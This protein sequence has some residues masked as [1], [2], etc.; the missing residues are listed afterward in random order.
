MQPHLL[1]SISSHGYGHAGQTAP[2][3]N[4][5]RREVPNLRV[6]LRTTLPA[7]FLARRFDGPF[8]LVAEA[9]DFGMKMV[10]AIEVDR[11]SSAK[12]YRAF[13]ANWEERVAQEAQRLRELRPDLILANVPY[14]TL[15]GAHLAAIPAIGFCSLNWADIYAGYLSNAGDSHV[16]TQIRA[17]YASAHMFVQ[18]APHMP[19]PDLPRRLSIGPVATLGSDCRRQLSERLQLRPGERVVQIAPGGMEYRLP[20]ERWP[21]IPNIRWIV[22]ASW[23]VARPDVVTFEAMGFAFP[24]LLRACDAL[25][26]KPGYGSFAEAAANGTPV[27]YVRRHDWPEEPFLV[28]WLRQHANA[29]E[30]D[31]VALERGDV[32]QP[33][34]E[35]WHQPRRP[36]V[37]PAGVVTAAHFL[38]DRLRQLA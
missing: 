5:L 36:A 21:M 33:L 37:T 35:L 10:S 38:A 29:L 12:A 20:M 3:L 11:D 24:D 18:P 26:T 6:T 28:D 4:A 17:A 14:L 30:I 9:T 7:T 1:V 34:A 23:D 8:E 22:P 31:R 16:L 13:H 15:A 2:V 32:T 25:I 19:M 27:L